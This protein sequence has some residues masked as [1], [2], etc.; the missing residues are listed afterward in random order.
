MMTAG[1]VSDDCGDFTFSV[2]GVWWTAC[3]CV[4]LYWRFVFCLAFVPPGKRLGSMT[5]M[6]VL[7]EQMVSDLSTQAFQLEDRRL[8]LFL[9]WLMDHSS[10][11]KGS[12]GRIDPGLREAEIHEHFQSALKTWLQSLSAQGLL[13]EY[14]TITAEI[15]WW[16]NLDPFRLKMVPKT[17]EE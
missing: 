11:M 8:R 5:E 9:N 12:I 10:E 1:W 15:C 16:R 2:G 13:W 4:D 6:D 3:L 14:Q 7:I 17:E